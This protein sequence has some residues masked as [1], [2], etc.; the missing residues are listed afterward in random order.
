MAWAAH[1]AI[2]MIIEDASAILAQWFS[3]AFP[4][5]GFAYSHGLEAA[6]LQN[7]DDLEQ[8]LTD[9]LRFGAGQSDA[10][11]ISLAGQAGADIIYI[12]ALARAFAPSKER[13][14]ESEAQGAAFAATVSKIWKIDLPEMAYAVAV[15]RAAA[16]IGLPLDLTAR[17]Y[18]LSFTSS[19]IAAAQRLAP[20]GQIEGQGILHRPKTAHHLRPVDSHT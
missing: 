4:I 18:L 17:H 1:M 10:I 3:P 8:W 2:P 11:L 12:D 19:L 20:I 15:G 14:L 5:G 7:G 13:L 9:I 16:L 6:D